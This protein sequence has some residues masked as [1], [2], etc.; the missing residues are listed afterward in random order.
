MSFGIAQFMPCPTCREP[1]GS[2]NVEY[3]SENASCLFGCGRQVDKDTGICS[4]CKEHSANA[5]ECESCGVEYHKW[6]GGD[7][8]KVTP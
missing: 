5:V 2:L 3:L 1:D 4:H 7:W 8:Q 6:T